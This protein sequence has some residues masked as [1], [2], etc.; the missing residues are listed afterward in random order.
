MTTQSANVSVTL[1]VSQA[2]ER[3]KLLL[4]QPFDPGKWF[5]I[6]FCA[7]LAHLGEQ[8]FRGNYN[9]GSRRDVGNIREAFEHMRAFV[10]ENLYWIL[11]LAI[12]VVI[13]SVALGIVMMWLNSRG[14]FMFLHCVALD[15]TEVSVPWHK[16]AREGNSLFLFRLVLGLIGMIAMLPLVAVAVVIVVG[17]V[18]RGEPDI[19]SILLLVGILLMLIAVGLVFAVIRKLTTDFVV[20]IMFLRGVNCLEGWREFLRLISANVANFVVYLLFQLALGLA[21]GALVLVVIIAT[22][23][24]ACC[25]IAIPYLG[26]VLLLPVLVFQRSYSLHYLA[27]YGRAYDVFPP[28]T[29][30]A[31][32]LASPLAPS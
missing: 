28:V 27:Q 31:P 14:K 12:A 25:L 23:C 4:F 10:M 30:P 1:P 5:T 9:F 32:G 29:A 7:W 16:F 8:G 6:G 17:M 19:H 24:I 2:I 11:P 18:R 13:I 3:V 20:P 21:T 26:T 22:C 15:R